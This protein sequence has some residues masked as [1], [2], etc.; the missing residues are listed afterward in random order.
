[1]ARNSSQHCNGSRQSPITFA[2]TKIENTGKTV[3]VTLA[4]GVGVEGGGLSERYDSLQFHLHWGNGSSVP[5]SEHTVDANL[6]IV[7]LK[8]SHNGNTTAGIA[9]LQDFH[10]LSAAVLCEVVVLS[11]GQSV[12]ISSAISLTQLLSGVDRTKY[13]RYLG[14]LPHQPAMRMCTIFTTVHVNTT[15]SSPLMIDVYRGIQPDLAVRTQ[16]TTGSATLCTALKPGTG[17]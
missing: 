2:L 8:S 11:S 17:P 14:S 1:M 7:N 3:K 16:S 5:G 6:H 12:A 9:I 15:A 13:Y 10:T 4:G